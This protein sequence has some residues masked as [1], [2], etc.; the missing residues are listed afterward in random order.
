MARLDTSQS[1]SGTEPNAFWKAVGDSGSRS[2]L[3]LELEGTIREATEEALQSGDL[4]FSFR[5]NREFVDFD[6]SFRWFAVNGEPY[7]EKVLDD[8]CARK[9]QSRATAVATR[10]STNGVEVDVAVPTMIPIGDA[11]AALVLPDLG[12]TIA[13]TWNDATRE[14]FRRDAFRVLSHLLSAGVVWSGFSPR[15]I[16]GRVHER[17]TLIDL[18]NARM[19]EPSEPVVDTTTALLWAL[20]WCPPGMD[21]RS[22]QEE[23]T[24]VVVDCGGQ[25][26]SV[27]SDPYEAGYAEL[28]G[29]SIEE[30]KRL[31]AG[32]TRRSWRPLS[33]DSSRTLTLTPA[34]LCRLVDDL[35]PLNHAVIATCALADIRDVLDENSQLTILSAIERIIHLAFRRVGAAS[36]LRF[37][38]RAAVDY[39]EKHLA[40]IL[41]NPDVDIAQEFVTVGDSAADS[42]WRSADTTEANWTLLAR[43]HIEGRG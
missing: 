29:V 30:S 26:A 34:E 18:E 25:V 27:D 2:G 32:A 37:S 31:C 6:S 12:C 36:T 35:L 38:T 16:C 33:A 43:R 7:V 1:R 13:E 17:W 19:A 42:P 9:E 5:R 8:A 10:M 24:R 21:P 22:I 20:D 40:R 14:D 3:S 23:I 39:I 28:A 11:L 4:S 15:N 41:V